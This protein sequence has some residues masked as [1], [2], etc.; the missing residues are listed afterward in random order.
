MFFH[1]KFDH[2]FVGSPPPRI[3]FIVCATP[4]CGSSL[5]C[6]LL[7]STE[8][9]GA[10]TEFFDLEQMGEFQ[11]LWG[12]AT[13]DDYVEALFA[14]KTSP[15]GVFGIKT[16]YHQLVDAFGA[17]EPFGRFP[18]LHLVYVRRLDRL[19]QAVSFARATQ[20]EQWSSLHKAPVVPPTYDREQIRL[21]LHW[22]E[23]E[24]AA[25]EYLF[26]DSGAPLY[27][28][29]YEDFVESIEKTLI[30]VV[31]FLEIELPPA[32]EVPEPTL[33]RQADVLTEEWIAR[34]LEEAAA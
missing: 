18:N 28:V 7:A 17:V 12:T 22:I 29:I 3:S 2:V 6:E 31:R 34:Y 33:H 4:R 20:T 5:L 16:H 14:K 32:F 15:N 9:A 11:R 23:R 25:W 8:L 13:L 19:R 1:H 27:R 26:G 10:P 21:M 30:D 24:E